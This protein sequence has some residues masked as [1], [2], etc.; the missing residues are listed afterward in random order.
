MSLK[1]FFL[2]LSEDQLELIC[3]NYVHNWIDQEL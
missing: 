3:H 2:D 1:K